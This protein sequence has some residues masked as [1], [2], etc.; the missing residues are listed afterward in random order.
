MTNEFCLIADPITKSMAAWFTGDKKTKIQD[1]ATNLIGV[2]FND[3]YVYTFIYIPLFFGYLLVSW[4]LSPFVLSK[5]LCI[6]L[7]NH[8]TPTSDAT[9]GNEFVTQWSGIA[10]HSGCATRNATVGWG[11]L[12]RNSDKKGG[13][14]KFHVILS[15]WDFIP[16]L[17]CVKVRN[18]S[19]TCSST[20]I[21]YIACI[22]YFFL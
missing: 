17:F 22:S 19:S 1:K 21:S 15:V 9:G 12:L 14:V 18:A 6:L 8:F 20:L 11:N 2:T 13:G 16:V 10:S 4:S 5:K 7:V 3:I